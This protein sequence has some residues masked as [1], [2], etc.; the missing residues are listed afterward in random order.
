MTKLMGILNVTPDSFFDKGSYFSLEKAVA[1]G[2][3]IYLEGADI[4]DIGGESTRPGAIPVSA[5]EELERVV[6]VIKTLHSCI[7]I[8]ISI[9]TNKPEVALAAVEAGA[10]LINDISGFQN[11]EMQDLAASSGVQICIMHMQG[12]PQNMQKNPHYSNGVVSFLIQWFEQQLENLTKKGIKEKQII[13]DPGIGFGKTVDDN[14]EILQNLP[15]LKALG[16]PLLIGVSRKSF[17]SKILN[18]STSELLPATIAM[19]TLL[20][21]A[22]VDIIRVHDVI[23]HRG[24]IDLVRAC[25]K[26]SIG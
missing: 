2:K 10:S 16:F 22:E 20:I 8:P 23:E 3:A 26:S 24:V 14:L 7:P 11:P 17:M 5:Q 21:K 19:N 6:T 9:D 4:L 1:R 18:K 15:R 12:T 13:L 25:S